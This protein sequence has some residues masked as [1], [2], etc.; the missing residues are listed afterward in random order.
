VVQNRLSNNV[1][2]VKHFRAHYSMHHKASFAL[3]VAWYNFVRVKHRSQ[4]DALHGR[5]HH[6][7]DL[8]DAGFI[9]CLMLR[10]AHNAPRSNTAAAA[11]MRHL[12]QAHLA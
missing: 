6:W 5:W 2:G 1:G 7:N 11:Q 8:D 4:D 10:C 9:G 12:W 3:W